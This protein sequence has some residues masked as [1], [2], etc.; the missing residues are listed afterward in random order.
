MFHFLNLIR[1]K[2]LLMIALMQLLIK[3]ALFEPFNVAITLNGFGFSL[4]V[5]A[6]LCIAAAGYIINDIYDVET[7][8][9]NKPNKVIIDK[10]ISEKTAFNL[11]I[12]FTIIGVGLGFYL[13]NLIGKSGFATLFVIISALLYIYATYLKQITLVGNIVVSALVAFSIIIVG[14]FELLP[15]ITSQNQ[16]TQLTFFTILRDYAIFAFLINFIREIVKDIEDIDGDYKTDM[17]TLPIVI[18]R[19]RAGKVVF[20]LSLISLAIIIYYVVTY[21]YKHNIAVGYFLIF[22]IAPLLYFSV[23]SFT[24]ETNKEWHYLSNILKLILLFGIL[25]LLLY[26]YI[27]LK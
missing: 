17:K 26:K 9:V 2:N 23:K 25:S 5:I 7:D 3:Y 20:A 4:L 6:T 18:G 21:L 15:V 8:I 10:H 19:D 13:S 12:V 22:V 14:L 16:Q 27:L 1:W 24:A 11:Y